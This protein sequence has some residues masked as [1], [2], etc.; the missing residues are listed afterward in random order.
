[1]EDSV[2]FPDT[3]FQAVVPHTHAQACKHFLECPCSIWFSVY[4]KKNVLKLQDL[5]VNS[6]CERKLASNFLKSPEAKVR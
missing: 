6:C 5:L 1:M 4:S 2:K 3:P